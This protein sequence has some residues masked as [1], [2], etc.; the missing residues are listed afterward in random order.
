MKS[1]APQPET[2]YYAEVEEVSAGLSAFLSAGFSAGFSV[3]FPAELSAVK[4][5]FP[6]FEE[7]VDFESVR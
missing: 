1:Q 5:D 7:L 3:D 4:A 6:A 2:F